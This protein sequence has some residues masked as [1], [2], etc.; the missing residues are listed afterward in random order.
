MCGTA[1]PSADG[2][3]SA[4]IFATA[5]LLSAGGGISSRRPLV[6]L[7]ENNGKEP[8][9]ATAAAYSYKRSSVARVCFG[10]IDEPCRTAEPIKMPF[11]M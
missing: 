11:G 6:W 10:H 8:V 5:E 7:F 2:R 3:R 4:A 1:D 9:A